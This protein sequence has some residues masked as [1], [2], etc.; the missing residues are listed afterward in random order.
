MS[1]VETYNEM[2]ARLGALSVAELLYQLEIV[3]DE[4]DGI[5]KYVVRLG[6]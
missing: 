4:M 2:R 6:E 5:E 1:K 3:V